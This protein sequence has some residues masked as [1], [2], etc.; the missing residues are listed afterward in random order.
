MLPLLCINYWYFSSRRATMHMAGGSGSDLRPIFD[1]YLAKWRYTDDQV[2]VLDE[3]KNSSSNG[4]VVTSVMSPEQYF[5][6]AELYT[7]TFLSVVSHETATAIS[8]TEKA[9]LTE[10]DR[11]VSFCWR[12]V[13]IDTT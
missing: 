10:Q 8:W 6:V 4:L 7:V 3:G 13:V 11:Q 1:E 5:E 2:Y 12:L 9:E